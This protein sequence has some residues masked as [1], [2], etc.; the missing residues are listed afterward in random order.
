MAREKTDCQE[1][2]NARWRHLLQ[3]EQKAVQLVRIIPET[4][5]QGE[6]SESEAL[7]FGYYRQASQAEFQEHQA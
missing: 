1:S 2:A 5:T 6:K 7:Y 3:R 4:K